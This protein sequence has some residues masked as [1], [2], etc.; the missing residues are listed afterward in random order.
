[1][2]PAGVAVVEPELLQLPPTTAAVP[3]DDTNA[4]TISTPT[5]PYASDLLFLHKPPGLLTLPGIGPDKADCLASR[6]NE[7]LRTTE[8]SERP[9]QS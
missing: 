6:T 2:A 1:M 7:W 8:D 4:D 3:S 5:T 9:R